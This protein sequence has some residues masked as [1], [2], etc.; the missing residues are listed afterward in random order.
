[1]SSLRRSGSETTMAPHDQL[2]VGV[3]LA[4]IFKDDIPRTNQWDSSRIINKNIMGY[5]IAIKFHEFNL[6]EHYKKSG[7]PWLPAIGRHDCTIISHLVDKSI[8]PQ[9]VQLSLKVNNDE[10]VIFYQEANFKCPHIIEH[11]T[12]YTSINKGDILLTGSPFYN[13]TALK[14]GDVIEG[15]CIYDHHRVVKAHTKLVLHPRF[16]GETQSPLSVAEESAGN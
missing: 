14:P 4:I 2:T 8:D 16:L 10:Q 9:S 15:A 11:V 6:L 7:M 5:F 3:N 12:K 1:M 13:T